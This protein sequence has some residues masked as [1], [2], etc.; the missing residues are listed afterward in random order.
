VVRVQCY[1]LVN[2][3][4]LAVAHGECST[5]SIEETVEKVPF[6]SYTIHCSTNQQYDQKQKDVEDECLDVYVRCQLSAKQF[7]VDETDCSVD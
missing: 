4:L 6:L 7:D 5:D 1:V 2:N 3:V